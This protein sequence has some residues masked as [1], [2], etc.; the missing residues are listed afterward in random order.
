LLLLKMLLC[1]VE[2]EPEL[3]EPHQ[4]A[5]LIGAGQIG[6]GITQ[7]AAVLFECEE[8]QHARPGF[9]LERKV[10]AVQ[11]RGVAAKWDRVEIEREPIGFGKDHRSEGLDPPLQQATL[12]VADGPV[13]TR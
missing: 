1:G 11:R 9:A 3:D 5:V 13:L 7:A 8:G 2:D 12:L 6:V 10:M 4:F